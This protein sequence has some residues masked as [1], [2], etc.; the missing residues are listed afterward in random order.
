MSVSWVLV[1]AVWGQSHG[2]RAEKKLEGMWQQEVTG[3]GWPGVLAV[4]C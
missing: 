1:R 4:V 2:G 3:A